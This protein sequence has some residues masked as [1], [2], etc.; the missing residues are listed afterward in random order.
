MTNPLFRKPLETVQKDNLPMTL[1]E[2]NKELKTN[3]DYGWRFTNKANQQVSSV[4]STLER[5]FGLIK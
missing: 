2:W 5:A 4:A 1:A 3:P